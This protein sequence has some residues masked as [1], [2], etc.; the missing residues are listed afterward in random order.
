MDRQREIVSSP[1][2]QPDLVDSPEVLTWT[3]MLSFCIAD[4]EG[5]EGEEGEALAVMRSPRYRSSSWAFLRLST[6]ETHQRLGI[7]A[8]GLQWPVEGGTG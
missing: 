3:W 6:L 2:L 4:G 8:R 1:G 7:R 5:E